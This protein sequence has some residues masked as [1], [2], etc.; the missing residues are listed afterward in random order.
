MIKFPSL[1]VVI[2]IGYSHT[3]FGKMLIHDKTQ[4]HNLRTILAFQDNYIT[5][6][7]YKDYGIQFILFGSNPCLNWT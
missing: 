5:I 4:L 6:E 2:K 7:L 3:G 1:S